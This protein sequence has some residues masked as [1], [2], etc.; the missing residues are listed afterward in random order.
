M[1]PKELLSDDEDVSGPEGLFSS[2]W[3]DIS[4]NLY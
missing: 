4:F 2:F 3:E 1:I